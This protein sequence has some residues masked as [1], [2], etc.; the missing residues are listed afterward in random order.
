MHD[1]ARCLGY[2]SDS[3]WVARQRA[4]EAVRGRWPAHWRQPPQPRRHSSTSRRRHLR[5]R[6]RSPMRLGAVP[7]APGRSGSAG[8]DTLLRHR[9]PAPSRGRGRCRCSHRGATRIRCG[10]GSL[11]HRSFLWLAS[12]LP[13][14]HW[15]WAVCRAARR[16][17]G[18]PARIA[19]VVPAGVQWGGLGMALSRLDRRQR[20]SVG[21]PAP[22]CRAPLVSRLLGRYRCAGSPAARGRAGLGDTGPGADSQPVRS[23]PARRV[24]SATASPSRVIGRSSWA[25][26]KVKLGP[27]PGGPGHA[28]SVNRPLAC[29]LAAGGAAVGR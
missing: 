19:T 20:R 25:D 13:T 29:S 4:R 10:S 14:S 9:P 7:P 1:T 11:L 24:S 26:R 5:H 6:P 3:S 22:V 12:G 8:S 27:A 15:P 2:P 28:I 17:A 16:R 23:S 21:G 18:S